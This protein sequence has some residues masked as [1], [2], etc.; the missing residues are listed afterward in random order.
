MRRGAPA[1]PGGPRLTAPLAQPP[2]ELFGP[3]HW[4]A[5]ALTALA[6]VALSVA[7]RRAGSDGVER[8]V[9]AGLAW[10][11]LGN[12]AASWVLAFRTDGAAVFW[13]EHLPLHVCGVTVLLAAATLLFRRPLAYQLTYFWGLAGSVNAILTPDL[14]VGYPSYA[15]LQFFVSHGGIVVA[16]L[17]ATW[18]LGMRPTL[19]GLAQ[20]VVWIHVVAVLVAG[21]NLALDSNYMYLS[22]PPATASPFVFLPWPWYLVVLEIVGVSIFALLYLPTAFAK[23]RRARAAR[24]IARG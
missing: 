23:R 5:V 17:F 16:A 7:V 21:V 15:F 6:P 19:R 22:A 3:A 14:E 1:R 9:R 24:S 8:A 13:R 11:L 20:A 4:A 10:I 18:G 12:E 2:F